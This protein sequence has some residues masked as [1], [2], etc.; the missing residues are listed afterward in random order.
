M[1]II[2]NSFF[3][4][5]RKNVKK[6]EDFLKADECRRNFSTDGVQIKNEYQYWFQFAIDK[7]T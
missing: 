2:S 1:W 4:Q 6:I 3:F 5:T 7:L